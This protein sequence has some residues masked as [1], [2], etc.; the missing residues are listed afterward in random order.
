MLDSLSIPMLLGERV[1]KIGGHG[2][3]SEDE[4]LRWFDEGLTYRQM[5]Q[6]TWDKYHLEIG[7]S[8][9]GNFRRRKGLEARVAR[10]EDLIPWSVKPEHEAH[11]FLAYLRKEARRR[12]GYSLT[13]VEVKRVDNFLR[14]LAEANVV[15][16]YDPE[17]ERGWHL[18]PREAQDTDIIRRPK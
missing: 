1:S 15:V 16:H 10:D 17:T 11:A 5:V 13:D 3:P 9:F 8:A 14:K 7:I 6:R 4:V 2:G 18:V 12:Q